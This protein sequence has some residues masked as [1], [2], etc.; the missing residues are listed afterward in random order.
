MLNDPLGLPDSFRA[1]IP[2]YLETNPPLL[3]ISQI[4]GFAFFT[5]Q[6]ATKL[7]SNS[8]MSATY[9]D[10]PADVGPTLT[11]LPG[12]KY[13]LLYG[14]SIAVDSAL[15]FAYMSLKVNATEAV[16]ADAIISQTTTATTAFGFMV[17]TLSQPQNTVVARYRVTAG[18]TGLFGSRE[19]V[20]LRYGNL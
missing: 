11:N 7:F 13:V 4:T 2:N 16:D 3:P 15:Y 5:A 14:C 19:L 9:T 18:G 12:G 20:A 8:T 10:L 1:W 6:P 17:A